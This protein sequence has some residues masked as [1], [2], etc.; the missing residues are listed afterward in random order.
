MDKRTGVTFNDTA[1]K[2]NMQYY[3]VLHS[4]VVVALVLG[5]CF[6]V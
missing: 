4:F 1:I 5:L 3:P 2:G 6:A